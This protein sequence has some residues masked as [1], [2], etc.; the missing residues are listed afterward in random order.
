MA[1][2]EA[3]GVSTQCIASQLRRRNRPL[4]YKKDARGRSEKKIRSPELGPLSWYYALQAI[5]ISPHYKKSQ[6]FTIQ[7]AGYVTCEIA[8]QSDARRPRTGVYKQATI[9]FSL[10]PDKLKPHRENMK[11]LYHAAKSPTTPRAATNNLLFCITNKLNF[12]LQTGHTVLIRTPPP[13]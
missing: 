8:S 6:Y 4:K 11:Q 5:T 3:A 13:P 1:N 2:S 10:H 12:H 9:H 7:Q